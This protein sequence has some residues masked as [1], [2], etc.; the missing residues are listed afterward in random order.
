LGLEGAFEQAGQNGDHKL[1]LFGG[2][3]AG[4][5]HYDGQNGDVDE[6]EVTLEVL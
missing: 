2:F 6:A 3:R 1:E 4:E 5:A